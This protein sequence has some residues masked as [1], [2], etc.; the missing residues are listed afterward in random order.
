M[1]VADHGDHLGEHGLV[2]HS[3][4]VFDPVVSVPM[5]VKYPGQSS[6][7]TVTAQVETRRLYQTALDCANIADS[8]LSLCG[9]AVERPA[10]GEFTTPMLDVDRVL[11]RREAAFHPSLR[12]ERLSFVR[13]DGLKLVRTPQEERLYRL[14]EHEEGA[15][16]PAD[17]ADAAAALRAVHPGGRG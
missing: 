5:V 7:E 10:F 8:A 15:A 6:R 3:C 2:G 11:E 9:G 14:P 17:H 13:Q 16:D 4:S 12:G 1:V